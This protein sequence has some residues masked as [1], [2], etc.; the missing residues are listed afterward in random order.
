MTLEQAIEALTIAES[1]QISDEVAEAI[2]TAI[3]EMKQ[4][5]EVITCAECRYKPIAKVNHKGFLICAASQMEITDTDFCS[6]GERK[7]KENING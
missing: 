6:Y 2:R 1:Q 3:A 7:E 5:G 4:R